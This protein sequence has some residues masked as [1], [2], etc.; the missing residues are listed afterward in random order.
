M[1]KGDV[2]TLTGLT[3]DKQRNGTEVTLT[4]GMLDTLGGGTGYRTN[5]KDN[6]TRKELIIQTKNL[7]IKRTVGD[8]IRDMAS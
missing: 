8:R 6:I 1:K 4:S 2:C 5:L 7:K 3:T